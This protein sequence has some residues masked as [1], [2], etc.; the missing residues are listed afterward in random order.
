MP[1]DYG[2]Q[3]SGKLEE[4]EILYLIEILEEKL[5]NREPILGLGKLIKNL[6]AFLPKIDLPTD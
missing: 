1:K 2:I 5:D 6:K 4:R 3:H